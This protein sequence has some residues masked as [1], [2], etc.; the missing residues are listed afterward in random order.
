VPR[1]TW[2]AVSFW[3]EN[4]TDVL[5]CSFSKIEVPYVMQIETQGL[6]NK[7]VKTYGPKMFLTL[8]FFIHNSIPALLN[9]GNYLFPPSNY[10][11]LLTCP[12]ELTPRPK[13][14]IQ[15]PTLH[16]LPPSVSLIRE[17]T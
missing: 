2:R 3:T 1:V 5:I 9:W 11:P 10:Q 17:K 12:H 15:L 8:N 6:E 16:T 14:S 7:V 4:L 13:E